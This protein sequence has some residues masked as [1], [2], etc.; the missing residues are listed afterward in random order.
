[1]TKSPAQLAYEADVAAKPRNL[2]KLWRP[3]WDALKSEARKY[4]EQRAAEK[5]WEACS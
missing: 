4:W 3:S 5:V 1:M 2:A